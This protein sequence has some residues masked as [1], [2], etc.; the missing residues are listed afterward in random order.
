M[1]KKLITLLM[2]LIMS[3]SLFGG[4][5]LITLE[6]TFVDSDNGLISG[7]KKITVRLVKNANLRAG[8]PGEEVWSETVPNVVFD[9]GFMSAELGRNAALDPVLFKESS[10]SFLVEIEGVGGRVSIPVRYVPRS[11]YA[12]RAKTALTML[13]SGIT[14][15]V[16]SA[17]V[18][19]E[20][21]GITGVG[22]LQTPLELARGFKVK[23]KQLVVDDHTGNVG[24][25]HSNPQY[26]LDVNGDML[27]R[28]TVVFADGTT[29]NSTSELSGSAHGVKSDD[30]VVVD[31]DQDHTGVGQ[32]KVLIGGTEKMRLTQAGKLG[33]GILK[34][35][36]RLDINGAIRI[37]DT[38]DNSPGTIRYHDNM[39]QGFDSQTKSWQRLDV[40]PTAAGGWSPQ[41]DN[42]SVVLTFPEA[43][44][45][46]GVQAPTERLAVDGKVKAVAFVGSGKG[47]TGVPAAS[48]DG[49]LSVAQGGLGGNDFK[50]TGLL[51]YSG[52][53]DKFR[54]T[55]EVLAGDILAGT[56][57]GVPVVHR[58]KTGAG[59]HLNIKDR[60]IEIGHA[61]TSTQP[62]I[63]KESGAVLM[64]LGLD[65]FGHVTGAVT[66]NL[67]D[68]YYAKPAADAAF[69][70]RAG[71][72][73]NGSLVFKGAPVA[74]TGG[75]NEDIVIH[76]MGTGRMGVGMMTPKAMLDVRGGIRVGDTQ[77][78]EPGTIRYNTVTRRLEG[79]NWKGWMPLDV[80]TTEN[81][82][83]DNLV[84]RTVYTGLDK[85]LGLGTLDPQ[86]PLHITLRTV[87]DGESVFN[88]KAVFNQG[89]Q[90]AGLTIAP[91][92]VSG[93][94]VFKQSDLS[95]IEDLS[96]GKIG[97]GLTRLPQEAMDVSGTIKLKGQIEYDTG[98][99]VGAGTLEGAWSM[100]DGML[101][102]VGRLE[103]G[104][105]Q[106]MGDQI[107]GQLA[108]RLA[109][110][111]RDLLLDPDIPFRISQ[112]PVRMLVPNRT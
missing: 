66:A 7:V 102:E 35:T 79:R 15:I 43:N 54:L 51:Y 40:E 75:D 76:P 27:V 80:N 72:E 47:L 77:I 90:V 39:Y 31:V 100:K 30:D 50:Q 104:T 20:Y 96:V 45:G 11:L 68:R 12:D 1:K 65:D 105:M 24:V 34:P 101:R 48:I 70:G 2:V 26:L 36:Q 25:G 73:L 9:N 19:G 58:L 13:S 44:V 98:N 5:Q 42:R 93:D 92:G 16:S 111:A 88:Q 109:G 3:I 112:R 41:D 63:E 56:A 33:V 14:G 81:G 52:P 89:L 62:S 18:S 103:V 99:R 74:I 108:L 49:I 83:W 23:G 53:E 57:A 22:V 82:R 94:M 95:G 46:I 110:G 60:V 64:S 78:E 8:D 86:H 6:G 38:N 84:D 107:Q 87:V 55:G 67:D 69:I 91:A 97:V 85:P 71:G 106:L 10:L 32:F 29:L 4:S 28:G 61:D 37:G 17:N 59:I 21:K